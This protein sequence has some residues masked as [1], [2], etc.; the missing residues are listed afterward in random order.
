MYKLPDSDESVDLL[1]TPLTT[2]PPPPPLRGIP[3]FNPISPL[4]SQLTSLPLIP[5]SLNSRPPSASMQLPVSVSRVNSSEP[6]NVSDLPLNKSVHPSSLTQTSR[7][8]LNRVESVETESTSKPPS[9]GDLCFLEKQTNNNRESP[10][11][12]KVNMFLFPEK[13]MAR[14]INCPTGDAESAL[15]P[16]ASPLQTQLLR[17]GNYVNHSLMTPNSRS[18]LPQLTQVLPNP[19]LPA[20]ISSTVSSQPVL[21]HSTI[22]PLPVKNVLSSQ[23]SCQ[24]SATPTTLDTTTNE[25]DL[26]SIEQAA[27]TQ[28]H[29]YVQEYLVNLHSADRELQENISDTS[30]SLT[31][32]SDSEEELS[33]EARD[34]FNP[35]KMKSKFSR[36]P[37]FSSI[38]CTMIE[39]A[40]DGA[41]NPAFLIISC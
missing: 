33:D 7:N 8:T 41:L 25:R 31:I 16:S 27:P 13:T 28:S 40:E 18:Q 17:G 9:N 21:R 15:S 6:E 29:R 38:L 35:S 11:A 4:S 24:E 36:L 12:R 3:H 23:A 2:G 10:V 37:L 34:H 22:P 1:P 39:N 26:H 32:S 30:S 14:N 5:S 20:H 19:R